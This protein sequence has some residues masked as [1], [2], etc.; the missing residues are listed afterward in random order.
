M[1]QQFWIAQE[2]I[3]EWIKTQHDDLEASLDVKPAGLWLS[4]IPYSAVIC[5]ASGQIVRQVAM[6]RL[7]D[8]PSRVFM[9]GIS[10]VRG[11][12]RLS[13]TSEQKCTRGADMPLF[14]RILE[15]PLQHHSLKL[16]SLLNHIIKEFTGQV[17]EVWARMQA[18]IYS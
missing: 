1:M 15:A 6:T 11:S 4:R 3:V 9:Q 17:G 10:K 14:H 13:K 7:P 5:N 18:G 12:G 8:P 16:I 2:G